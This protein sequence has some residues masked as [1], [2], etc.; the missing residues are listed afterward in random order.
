MQLRSQQPKFKD[1]KI[2]LWELFR[3][4]IASSI[5]CKPMFHHPHMQRKTCVRKSNMKQKKDY[6]RETFSFATKL[7]TICFTLL[8]I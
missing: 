4:Q 7:L 3:K 8:A 5:I 6:Q 2:C 1:L